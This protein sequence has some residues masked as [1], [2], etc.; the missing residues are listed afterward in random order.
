[1]KF[2]T[3][4]VFILS[5]RWT[6]VSIVNINSGNVIHINGIAIGNWL[7]KLRMKVAL[8]LPMKQFGN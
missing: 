3:K 6:L 5:T 2:K 1:M 4:M 8:I 7:V